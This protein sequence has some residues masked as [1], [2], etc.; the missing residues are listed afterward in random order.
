MQ[1]LALDAVLDISAGACKFKY[2]RKARRPDRETPGRDICNSK[3]V[4]AVPIRTAAPL[5]PGPV[6]PWLRLVMMTAGAA[7]VA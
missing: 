6:W 3:I 7:A 2:P 5:T 1:W 4:A